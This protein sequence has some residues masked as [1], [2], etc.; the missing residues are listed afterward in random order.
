[1]LGRFGLLLRRAVRIRLETVSLLFLLGVFAVSLALKPRTQ[2]ILLG[3]DSSVLLLD[4][5]V[6]E[7]LIDI[8]ESKILVPRELEWFLRGF[9]LRCRRLVVLDLTNCFCIPDVPQQFS[10]DLV[11]RVGQNPLNCTHVSLQ[12]VPGVELVRIPCAH[13]V[14]TRDL[15]ENCGCLISHNFL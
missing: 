1:V 14:D 10:P 15:L 3:R 5:F 9:G 12:N 7:A 4:Y 8:A 2:L 6:V 11:V 13:L